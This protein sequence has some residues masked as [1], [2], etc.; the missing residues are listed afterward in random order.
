MGKKS[1]RAV[2]RERIDYTQLL[3]ELQ[4]G[5]AAADSLVTAPVSTEDHQALSRFRQRLMSDEH[6]LYFYSGSGGEVHDKTCPRTREIL[7]QNL[8]WSKTY[9]NH[10]PQ[11]SLCWMKAYLRLGARDLFRNSDYES[12]FAEM[13]MT[14]K[15]LRRM[16]VHKGMQTE[17]IGSD[18]LKIRCRED[19]WLLEAVPGTRYLRLFH[20]NYQAN[21]DGS[22]TFTS[23]YHE[24]AV[25]ACAKYAVKVIAGYTYD[26][27]QAALAQRQ[28]I[29]A[30]YF[31]E[32]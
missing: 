25:C 5:S 21:A 11:C 9:P 10:L 20:N 27:H 1:T 31:Y 13:G 26:G 12:L 28:E 4:A 8:R 16:Y 23:G 18:R 15:L 2:P 3:A 19:T 17:I 22:R 32:P 6:I 30:V 14:S 24:Q 29:S 7:D